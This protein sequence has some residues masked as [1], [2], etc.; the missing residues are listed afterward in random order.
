MQCPVCVTLD[1]SVTERQSIEIDYCPTC[2][3]VW[4]D[5]GELDKLIARSD[6]DALERRRD[7]A[8]GAT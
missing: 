2:R 8:R 4:L 5:R 1:L 6:D 7:A 3:G